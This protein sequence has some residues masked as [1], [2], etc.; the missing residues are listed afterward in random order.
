MLYYIVQDVYD[1]L[2]VRP[3]RRGH[4]QHF[5]IIIS[6]HLRNAAAWLDENPIVHAARGY[7]FYSCV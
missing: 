1:V 7:D 2:H 4:Y 5:I 6:L 3:P